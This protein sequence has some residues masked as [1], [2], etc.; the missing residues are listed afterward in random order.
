VAVVFFA[1]GQTDVLT[2]RNEQRFSQQ[3]KSR[4]Y[5]KCCWGGLQWLDDDTTFRENRSRITDI[6]RWYF[7]CD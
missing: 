4:A 1:C 3:Y 7:L 5:E 6:A 2:F